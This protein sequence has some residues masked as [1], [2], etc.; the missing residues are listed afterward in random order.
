MIA[1]S[2]SGATTVAVSAVKELAK[3][4]PPWRWIRSAAQKQ[5]LR[6]ML[7]L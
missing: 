5:N 3:R 6:Q 7:M 2:I 1:V 4:N